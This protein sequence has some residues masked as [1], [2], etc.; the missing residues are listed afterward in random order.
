MVLAIIVILAPLLIYITIV[1]FVE[2]RQVVS[3]AYG[4]CVL[5]WIYA[6]YQW[7][8]IAKELKDTD[9]S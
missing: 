6:G 8:K 3:I 4:I 9:K 7:L 5:V 2:N 1:S